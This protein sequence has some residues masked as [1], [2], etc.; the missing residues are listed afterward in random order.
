MDT[1]SVDMGAVRL[2]E[3]DTNVFDNEKLPK[4]IMFAFV[5]L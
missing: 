4:E 3:C 5:L 2:T 1:G